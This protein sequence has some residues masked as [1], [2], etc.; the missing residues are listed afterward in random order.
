MDRL[1]ELWAKDNE[2]WF[3]EHEGKVGKIVKEHPDKKQND[4]DIQKT[5]EVLF[6]LP[7]ADN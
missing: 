7:L 6:K 3:Y 1:R 2:F 5:Q 4:S